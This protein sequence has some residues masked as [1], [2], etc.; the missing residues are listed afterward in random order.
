MKS[1]K[2]SEMKIIIIAKLLVLTLAS[3]EEA[4]VN[5]R[6]VAKAPRSRLNLI[7]GHA[8]GYANI[9]TIL[10]YLNIRLLLFLL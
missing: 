7:A 8:T 4:R 9:C 5:G 6:G 3:R 2:R 10:F 1:A